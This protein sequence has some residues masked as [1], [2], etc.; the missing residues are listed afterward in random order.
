MKRLLI[1]VL[2]AALATVPARPAQAGLL[3]DLFDFGNRMWISM[4]VIGLAS[5]TLFGG[6]TVADF[7]VAA[8]PEPVSPIWSGLNIGVGGII[9]AVAT[10]GLLLDD[11]ED[12]AT[13]KLSIHAFGSFAVG[14]GVAGLVSD[15][16]RDRFV[17]MGL[18]VASSAALQSILTLAGRHHTATTSVVQGNLALCGVAAG[19]GWAID[20]D[21]D[22]RVVALA[23]AGLAAAVAVHGFVDAAI[24]HAPVPAPPTSAPSVM[25]LPYLGSGGGG[26]A[27]VGQF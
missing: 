25:L 1:P 2:C 20:S 9:I 10:P 21:S 16:P 19:I 18:G 26:L 4:L 24:D 13:L 11:D 22:E 7:A 17:G 5:V 8:Q 23:L 12:S 15:R 3:D 27:A 14:F 6:V